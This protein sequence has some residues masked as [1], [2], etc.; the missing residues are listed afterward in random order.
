MFQMWTCRVLPIKGKATFR[1]KYLIL[2]VRGMAS[3]LLLLM[4]GGRIGVSLASG[5]LT[6]IY[7]CFLF[8]IRPPIL[9]T[10]F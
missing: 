10:H 2:S 8:S 3:V 6:T 7:H 1:G 5:L 4:M 9:L